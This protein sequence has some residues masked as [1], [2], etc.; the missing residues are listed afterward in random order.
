MDVIECP[1]SCFFIAQA[2]CSR[3]QS[4]TPRSACTHILLLNESND[5]IKR[6]LALV[7]SRRERRM[8]ST[9]IRRES[10]DAQTRARDV[11]GHNRERG[12][13]AY[14]IRTTPERFALRFTVSV[15][16]YRHM[17]LVC[18]SGSKSSFSK[19]GAARPFI[20]MIVLLCKLGGA[21]RSTISTHRRTSLFRS[22]LLAHGIVCRNGCGLFGNELVKCAFCA[23]SYSDTHSAPL[24]SAQTMVSD[25][26]H[27]AGDV[28]ALLIG[29]YAD[30]V[31]S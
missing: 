25:A 13:D 30:R 28:M 2:D 19:P 1:S 18:R 11:V 16:R 12:M 8:K 15:S 4:F 27:L 21:A 5:T 3:V 24:V 29:L 9:R 6:I 10:V 7:R 17:H 23:A 22:L 14:Q 26:F 20:A 31:S